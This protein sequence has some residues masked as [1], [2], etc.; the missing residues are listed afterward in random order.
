MAGLSVGYVRSSPRNGETRCGDNIQIEQTFT[1][2]LIKAKTGGGDLSTIPI[3][4]IGMP[5]SGTTLVEQ[6]VASHPAVHGA[7][8][9]QTLNDVALTVH[10]PHGN[11]IPYP[12]FV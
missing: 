12:A 9:L 5:R 7:G 2:E 4:I 8:E 11:T 1:D 10:G 6:I 3:F